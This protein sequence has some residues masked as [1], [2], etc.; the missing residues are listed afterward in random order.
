MNFKKRTAVIVLISVTILLLGYT[1]VLSPWLLTWGTTDAELAMDLPGD[2]FVLQPKILMT[3]AITVDVLPQKVWPWIV[4]MGQDRAGFCSYER[5]ERLFGFGI[6][7][8]YRITP[9]WQNLQA[10]DFVKFHQNGIGMQVVSVEKEKNILMLTDSR[11]PMKG[12]PGKKE[13]ILPLPEGMYTV[14]DWDFNLLPLPG[15]KTRLI[16]RA[17]ANWSFSNSI[18]KGMLRFVIGF[19]S[20]IMQRKMLQEIKQCSEGTHPSLEKDKQGKPQGS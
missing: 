6:H 15:G 10:G 7:N 5:L 13:L 14:W 11:K 18:L 20:S 4:Q 3:Q 8:T 2:R 9:Q 12:E 16:V 17:Y 1:Y 19:P